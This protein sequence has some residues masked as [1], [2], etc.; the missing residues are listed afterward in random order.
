[1][2]Q[3][4]VV[5]GAGAAGVAAA[6]RLARHAEAGADLAITVVERS[7]DHL[8]LP[9][10]VPVLFGDAEPDAVA[11]PVSAVVRPGVQVVTGAV[12]TLDPDRRSV[13]GTFG[14]IG[15]DACVLA[16]GAEVGWP[17]GEPAC[18]ELAPW[19]VAGALAGRAALARR[20]GPA[21][22]IA[23]VPSSA[24]YRCPPAVFDLAVRIR[25]TT[26]AAVVVAHPWP[27]PLHPFGDAPARAFERMLANAGVPFHGGF[28]LAAIEPGRLRSRSGETVAYDL[29]LVVPPHRP[30]QAVATSP[31][32]GPDGWPPVAYPQLTHPRYPAVSI[33]GDLAAPALGVGMAGTLAVFAA[34]YVADRIAAAAGGP[35]A[36]A[37]PRM[38]ALCFV[39]D[40]VTGSL[41]HC[42]FTGP[43]AG[44]GPPSC[45]LL[46]PLPYF[47]RARRLF[48]EAWFT[49]MLDG[50][51]V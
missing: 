11:R 34:G 22:R 42:D 12:T 3:Q 47:R 29:A 20:A 24:S 15:Y 8:F 10:L 30:P 28:Q 6:N 18:G 51:V 36:A 2:T 37:G 17:E 33:V 4:V 35:P 21:T 31:L 45:T 43:A 39:D 38:A 7:P 23:V 13:S 19:T 48:A 16:L 25:R 5:C 9:A 40:G 27:R 44:T 50:S 1:M 32:A 46:P 14:T 49:E 26:G 41:L